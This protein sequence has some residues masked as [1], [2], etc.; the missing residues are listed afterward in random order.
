[1]IKNDLK[2]IGD[3]M[4]KVLKPVYED[5]DE[6]KKTL[7]E[8]TDKIDALAGDV[9]QLQDDVKGIKEQINV[10]TGRQQKDIERLKKHTGLPVN[11][12]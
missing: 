10:V 12:E 11:A 2:Q 9:I 3:E 4:V 5:L 7:D 6:I 8:H 1:M